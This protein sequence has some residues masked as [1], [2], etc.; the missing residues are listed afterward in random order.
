ML[1]NLHR[2]IH[3]QIFCL[4]LKCI[5]D[6][7][8]SIYIISILWITKWIVILKQTDHRLDRF[9]ITVCDM[10]VFSLWFLSL[11]IIEKLSAGSLFIHH[12]LTRAMRHRM[13]KDNVTKCS[14]DSYWQ[15]ICIS[16][17]IFWSYCSALCILYFKYAKRVRLLRVEFSISLDQ[18]SFN[19][20]NLSECYVCS[21]IRLEDS[22]WRG[23]FY[24]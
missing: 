16:D 12:F 8:L 3:K 13:I 6:L 17:T 23:H 5:F 19:V 21:W 11:F 22:N 9:Q 2:S 4:L 7:F 20:Y 10:L 24:K 1:C 14:T 18:W 15:N